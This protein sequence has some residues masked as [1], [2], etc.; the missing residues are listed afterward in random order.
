MQIP[1]LLPSSR[2]YHI[3]NLLER[4]YYNK[5]CGENQIYFQCSLNFYG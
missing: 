4:K 1:V 5:N 3:N 2:E